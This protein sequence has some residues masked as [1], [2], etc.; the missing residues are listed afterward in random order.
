MENAVRSRQ[1]SL[2]YQRL[3]ALHG[4]PL[5][6]ALIGYPEAAGKLESALEYCPGHE[7][8]PCSGC[9]GRP[10][11]CFVAK[12]EQMERSCSR[13]GIK[14]RLWEERFLREEVAYC[15]EAFGGYFPASLEPI[16]SY[17]REEVA[18]EREYLR[19]VI[20]AG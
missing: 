4:G 16:L 7:K 15:L 13:G 9:G 10:R 17:T 5:G 12:L 1:R 8:L 3:A 18:A 6:A 19:R 14:R 11:V 20:A 2:R